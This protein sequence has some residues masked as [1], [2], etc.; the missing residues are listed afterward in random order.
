MLLAAML[1]AGILLAAAFAVPCLTAAAETNATP[2]D[3]TP[4]DAAGTDPDA[5][6]LL[7]MTELSFSLYTYDG[8]KIIADLNRIAKE[9]GCLGTWQ[10]RGIANPGDKAAS[11]VMLNIP[12]A[13]AERFLDAVSRVGRV[14]IISQKWGVATETDLVVNTGY[15]AMDF[16]A[17]HGAKGVTRVTILL[18][19]Q[20]TAEENRALA[21]A[22]EEEQKRSRTTQLVFAGIGVALGATVAG[23][24]AARKKR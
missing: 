6:S 20:R 9:V 2:T 1:L 7:V 19:V 13:N 8:E 12:S 15:R 17:G 10:N 5:E 18:H 22:R 14:E 21:Q 16:L 11:T 24:R 3:A 4:T 23:I